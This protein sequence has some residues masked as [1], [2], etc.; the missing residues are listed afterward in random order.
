MTLSCRLPA[1]K[2]INGIMENPFPPGGARSLAR[3]PRGDRGRCSRDLI[4]STK[5]GEAAAMTSPAR[6]SIRH[7]KR[8]SAALIWVDLRD[9][10]ALLGAIWAKPAASD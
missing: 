5:Q 4:P 7:V 3:P 9:F 6:P 2:R 8:V 10:G 1:S